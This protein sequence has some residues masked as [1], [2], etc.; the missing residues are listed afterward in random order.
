MKNNDK[1]LFSTLRLC[2]KV[3]RHGKFDLPG[4]FHG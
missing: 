1:T 4:K 2:C 3:R